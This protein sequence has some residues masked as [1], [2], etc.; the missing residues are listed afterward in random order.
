MSK[1]VKQIAKLEDLKTIYEG[2]QNQHPFLLVDL[3]GGNENL[4]TNVLSAVLN[5]KRYMFLESFL[6]RVVPIGVSGGVKAIS[7]KT[8]KKALGLKG[9]KPGFIDLYIECKNS[10]T[11][12]MHKIVIENKINGAG[13]TEKQMIRYIASIKERPIPINDIS[14][15]TDWEAEIKSEDPKALNALMGDCRNCHF[16]YL[17][18]DGTDPGEDSLPHCLYE[19]NPII[20]YYKINYQDDILPWLKEDVLEECPYSD[21]GIMIAG[22]QQYI[23]SLERLVQSNVQVSSVV[24]KYV[25]DI[26]GV[27]SKKYNRILKEMKSLRE[28]ETQEDNMS[29]WRELK[30]AAEN[31]YS[32]GAVDSPW[33]LHFTPSILLLYKQE[34]MT[35]GKGSYSIPFVNLCASNKISPEK[36]PSLPITIPWEIHIEHYSLTGERP[37]TL[38]TKYVNHDKTACIPLPETNSVEL[39]DRE[40]DEER[41]KYFSKI[42]EIA[43]RQIA[44]IDDSFKEVKKDEEV[45]KDDKLIG[46][47]LLQEI[48]SRLCSDTKS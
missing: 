13:D 15:F 8:Q 2:E 38:I 36:D 11:G 48:A 40:K 21:N 26:K 9:N 39:G 18:L 31:I 10:R 34:W 41:K 47:A 7:V 25:D 29:L 33:T 14:A 3:A 4:H 23:A 30:Q 32:E 12:A 20:N 27:D 28:T 5:F 44:G 16:V 19:N 6:E 17:S 43:E 24:Q 46:K 35:I 42:I 22:L 1:Q 37:N 45:L